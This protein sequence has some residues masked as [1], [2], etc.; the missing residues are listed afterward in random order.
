MKTETAGSAGKI[1]LYLLGRSWRISRIRPKTGIKGNSVLFAFW[2]GLQLPLMVT[3]RNMGIHL[4]ISKSRDGSLVSTVC[5]NLGFR[6]VR[7]SS[8]RG[9][10]SAARELV[11]TLRE[12]EV[13]AVTPDGPRGPACVV[14][15]GV[16]L[17]SKRAEVP[18]VPYGVSAFPAVRLK[19][20]DSFMIPLP[21][22]RL[23][24]SE[25]RPILPEHC[26][27]KTLTAAINSETGRAEL[28]AGPMA[29]VIISVIR[30]AGWLLTPLAEL[31]LLF[32]PS[33]ERRERKGL[34]KTNPHRPVWLHGASLGEL[35]GLL[36]AIDALKA[37]NISIF[38][39]CS[40][41]AAREFIEKEGLPGAFQPIDTQCAV[42]RFLDR[43]QPGALILAETEFWPVLLYETVSRGITAGMINARLSKKST[44]R[45]R[46]IRPLFRGIF[47]CFRGILTRSQID[48]DR[49]H[50]LGVKTET[51]G[52]GKAAVK[53]PEP[54]SRWKAMIK[55]SSNG[56]LVAGSTRKGEE[57]TVF[58]IARNAG[59]T[60][61]IV[62]RHENRIK[63]VLDIARASGFT[64]AL[65]T[66]DP[67]GASCIV[68]NVKGVLAALYGLA[69]IA[70]VGGT[71]VPV[72]GH[73]ILEPLAHGVPV[74]IGPLHH[75]F[76]D[77]VTEASRDNICRVFTTVDQGVAATLELLDFRK[78]SEN[79]SGEIDS[80][81]FLLKMR[82]LLKKMEIQV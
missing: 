55:Q 28:M 27:N 48:S 68:V 23:V 47:S 21:F 52:D 70:F 62:P 65:W 6:T 15:K 7:G 54:D 39:T 38:V 71:L 45:Y 63:E 56:I 17:I 16:S 76:T 11:S 78:R 3:H 30:F 69:D 42:G 8:S 33:E 14:K 41:P 44:E 25:G 13:A 77:V 66:D 60:P 81:I 24:I 80:G 58:E 79:D 53:P 22:A 73:N 50:E 40:T 72:G 4:L 31:V 61:V 20:W 37:A 32:R 26:D 51:A 82:I 10:T 9:G 43:L 35:K 12:G 19:S 49:F 18:V 57:K 34:I 46:L 59:L 36:P 74:I 1:L 5:E 29:S 75:H 2:H 67:M 64:P